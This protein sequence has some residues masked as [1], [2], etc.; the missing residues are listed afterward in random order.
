M[1]RT[2]SSNAMLQ[3]YATSRETRSSTLLSQKSSSSSQESI[4]GSPPKNQPHIS[5]PPS[6]HRSKVGSTPSNTTGT[7]GATETGNEDSDAEADGEDDDDDDDEEPEE[8]APSGKQRQKRRYQTGRPCT[9]GLRKIQS[10]MRKRA[11]SSSSEDVEELTRPTK[12]AK[13]MPEI[14]GSV[15][16]SD[17]EDYNAVDLISD[18][19]EEE[20]TVEKIEERMIIDSEEENNIDFVPRTIKPRSSSIS[21]DEWQGFDL[22]GGLFFSDMPFFD[23]QMGRMSHNDAASEGGLYDG[24][25]ILELDHSPSPPPARRVRFVDDVVTAYDST[26]SSNSDADNEVF[27]DLFMHQDSLDPGFRK[28]IE[29][30]N[31]GDANSTSDGE[32]SYW[33]LND[34]EDFELEKHGL[35]DDGDSSD[36]CG[37]SSGYESAFDNDRMCC[38]DTDL[39]LLS[40]SG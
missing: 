4:P 18:S 35:K 33:N 7:G 38:T 30:D 23:E 39:L 17:D 26:S 8:S 9:A 3:Q 40:R 2:I 24:G 34:N 31:D 5:T 11:W 21:S 16:E 15:N 10:T 14:G 13:S 32:G 29:N 22:E 12:A 37:S 6:P 19:D 28:M 25:S 36:S 27:P 1:A 20:P